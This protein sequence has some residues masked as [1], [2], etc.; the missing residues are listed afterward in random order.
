MS[1]EQVVYTEL[2]PSD[3]MASEEDVKETK[4]PY[5][6]VKLRPGGTRCGQSLF[7]TVSP[8]PSS[9]SP[10][11]DA[12]LCTPQASSLHPHQH[13]VNLG[14]PSTRTKHDLTQQSEK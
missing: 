6:D 8:S 10:V 9:L 4:H 7:G 13:P 3:S 11:S 2:D 1:G 14:A 5:T 12:S